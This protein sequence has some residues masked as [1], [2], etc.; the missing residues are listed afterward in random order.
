MTNA[1]LDWGRKYF[2]EVW[3]EWKSGMEE[4]MKFKIKNIGKHATLN[5]N[6]LHCS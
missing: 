1:F 2:D 5:L 4:G 3:P 6:K